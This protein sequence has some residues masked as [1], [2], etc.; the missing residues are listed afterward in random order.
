MSGR[1]SGQLRS[2]GPKQVEGR[3][4]RGQRQRQTRHDV[5]GSIHDPTDSV[6][7]LIFHAL[8]MIAEFE[9]DPCRMRTREGSKLA[10]PKTVA[11]QQLKLSRPQE[12][13]PASV[14]GISSMNATAVGARSS[15]PARAATT[16]TV[17]C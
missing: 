14:G 17:K 6:G 13:H 4:G 2:D 7:E 12:A 1:K 5:G 8:A 10:K 11:R 15:T 3:I 9:S 16:S